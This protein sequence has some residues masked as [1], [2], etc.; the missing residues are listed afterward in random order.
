M[1]IK[2]ENKELPKIIG[3][4]EQLTA[5]GKYSLARSRML[6]LTKKKYQEYLDEQKLIVENFSDKDEEGKPI[7]K[8]D[9]TFQ[10]SHSNTQAANAELAV[11]DDDLVVIDYREYSSRIKD[12]EDFLN[13]YEEELSGDNAQGFFDL[14][15]AFENKEE[16]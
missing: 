13:G 9:G 7:T 11:L 14:V 12:L 2:I 16:K 8:E 10:L 3:F 6:S 15:D 4:L 5:K 1:Q